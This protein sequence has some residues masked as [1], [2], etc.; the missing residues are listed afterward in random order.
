LL[1]GKLGLPPGAGK[2]EGGQ[3]SLPADSGSAPGPCHEPCP[4]MT[5]E[6]DSR[7]YRVR[8]VDAA[9][10]MVSHVLRATGEEH[11]RAQLLEAG[12]FLKAAEAATDSDRVDWSPRSAAGPKAVAAQASREA[13]SITGLAAK[14]VTTLHGRAGSCEG[15]LGVTR[16]GTVSFFP[17]D[18]S[19]PSHHFTPADAEAAE[20]AGFPL[21]MLRI[22]L[23]D[24]ETLECPAGFLFAGPVFRAVR[25]ALN[26]TLPG[27]TPAKR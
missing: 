26:D 25:D 9:G 3:T 12:L 22:T 10:R 13:P 24:G 4:P 19:K 8:A 21:R 17:R 7:K 15:H 6:A 23:L 5:N 27:R 1:R 18:T 11:A 14:V 2:A 20:I 16:E